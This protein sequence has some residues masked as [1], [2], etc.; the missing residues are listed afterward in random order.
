MPCI[1][2][3][4]LKQAR[5]CGAD[6]SVHIQIQ[7]E[8]DQY[9]CRSSCYPTSFPISDVR[10]GPVLLPTAEGKT[11]IGVYIDFLQGAMSRGE[12]GWP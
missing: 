3:S 10:R 9:G 8:K 12:G 5:K 6:S 2:V 11:A 4:W 7:G 1:M